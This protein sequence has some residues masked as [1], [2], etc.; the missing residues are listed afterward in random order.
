[1]DPHR[2]AEERSLA[3]HAAVAE[4]LERDPERLVEVR[5]VLDEWTRRNLIAAPYAQRWRELLEGPLHVLKSVLID[6]GE[7]ARALRQCTPFAGFVDA[8]TRW[9]IWRDVG[10][11]FGQAS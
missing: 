7:E 4:I 10:A 3:L 6:D 2:L 8:R 9:R 11:R 5:G 1:M